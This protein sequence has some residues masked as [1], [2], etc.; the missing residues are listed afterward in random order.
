MESII[1]FFAVLFV[2][3][4]IGIPIAIVLL[5]CA[6][7]L[8]LSLGYFDPM[9]LSLNMLE[10]INSFPLMAVPFFVLAGELMTKGGLSKRIV[11]FAMLMVGSVRGGLG[12]TVV[13]TSLLFAGLSGSGIADAAAIGGIMI[14]IMVYNNYRTDRA[15]ALVSSSAVLAPIVPPST[16]F[17]ILGT[18]CNLSIS[19]LFMG[20]LI[21]GV[22]I[23]SGLMV[24]WFF[25]VRKDGYQD[26]KTFSKQEKLAIL[27]DSVPALIFPIIIV[28][29]I[30]FGMFTPTEAGSVA[31][32]YAFVI[33]K[34]YYRELSWEKCFQT[35]INTVCITASIILIVSGAMAAGYYLTLA[36]IPAKLAVYLNTL[37]ETPLVFLIAVNIFLLLMG[38]LL[39]VTPNILIFAPILLPIAIKAG[40]NPY[41]FAFIIGFNLIIGAITPP[42]GTVLLVS[43]KVGGVRVSDVVG[44]QMPFLVAQIAILA[45]L[46]IFPQ[47]YLVPLRWL[48]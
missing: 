21:P 25:A 10:G 29:G 37:L 3:M 35:L 44:K 43:S 20:G 7:V 28:G 17:I 12:Y 41:Y 6:F 38:M 1:L 26:T 14:P 8:M 19:K 31:V 48:G 2:L 11:N 23:A 16:P 24:V 18:V 40:F 32:V 42:V 36:Q 9:S 45:L 34:F 13:L 33:C 15:T 39:D 22:M 47:L 30:R 5:I 27:L 46:I 4:G